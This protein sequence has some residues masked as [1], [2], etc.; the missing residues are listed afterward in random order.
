M[1]YQFSID[2]TNRSLKFPVILMAGIVCTVIAGYAFAACGDRTPDQA[3]AGERVVTPPATSSVPV[4]NVSSET[5]TP[6]VISGPVTFE[7]ADSAYRD[8]RYDDA[9]ALFKSYSESRPSNPWGFYMLGLSAWK[10]GDRVTAE[11]AFVQAITLDPT[12]VKSHLNLS[13]VLLE[14]EQADRDRK[15][16]V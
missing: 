6:R 11:S 15:S 5:S 14:T 1:S 13:R 3:R 10:S 8:R 16:V 4:S 2:Q 12:H 7:L 9:A